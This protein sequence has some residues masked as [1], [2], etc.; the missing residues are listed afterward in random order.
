MITAST[1]SRLMR[2][3]DAGAERLDGLV[4][5]L[6]RELVVA[7]ERVRP[8]RARQPR[9]AALLHQLEQVGR[10]VPSRP[11]CAPGPPSRRGRR[12]P[13]CSRAGRT[14][15]ARRRSRRPCARSRRRRRA[16]A[17]A[18]RRGS[19]RRRRRSPRTRRAATSYGR[20]APSSNSASVAT[21]TSLPTNTVRP[22]LGGERRPEREAAVPAGQVARAR[23]RAGLRRRR[24]PGEPTPTPCSARG[25]DPGG[26]RTPPSSPRPSPP[27]RPRGRRSSASAAAR[28]RARCCAASTTIAS[29]FVPPRSI[30]PR[31][32]VGR[33]S[34]ARL[35]L[36]ESRRRHAGASESG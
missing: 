36:P 18:C 27:P 5:Q 17:T 1:S 21:W 15:S 11:P 4:D 25:L 30:P 29:I 12:T 7:L 34:L 20:P 26:L 23:D 19:G 32:R 9:A 6:G 3:R 2:G 28:S 16:R 8:D 31:G 10:A 22:E 24:R 14:G 33:C 35:I 13:P